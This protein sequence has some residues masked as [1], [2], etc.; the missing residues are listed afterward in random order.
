MG[1]PEITPFFAF[2]FSPLG[3]PLA[4]NDLAP[5]LVVIVKRGISF[6]LGMETVDKSLVMLGGGGP[7]VSVAALLVTLP[8]V[9]KTVA[10]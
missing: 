10:V 2:N 8:A 5:K 3:S 6:P 1:L 7:T 4:A 9:L